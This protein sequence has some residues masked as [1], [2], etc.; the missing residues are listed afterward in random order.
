MIKEIDKVEAL[1]KK[2]SLYAWSN[3][4]P[5]VEDTPW[6]IYIAVTN[7][8]NYRCKVCARGKVMRSKQ[9]FMELSLF[10]KIVDELP[11]DMK[12]VYIM[13]QGETLLHPKLP[14]IL[15]YLKEKRPDSNVALHT[16]ASRLTRQL[17][18]EITKYT[19]FL[20][21]TISGITPEVY[22]E[23][24]GKN[25]FE[26]VLNNMREFLLIREKNGGRPK[27]V[28]IDYVRQEGNRKESD[29][30]VFRF[31]EKN[32]PALTGVG[33]HWTFN[34]QGTIDEGNL[35][36]YEQLDYKSF[37][38]CIFPWTSL[39][40]CWDGKVDY[41]FTEPQEN[42]FLGDARRETLMEIWNNSKY[43]EFRRLLSE[44]KFD[45]L[46]R[47]GIFCRKCSWLWSMESQSVENIVQNSKEKAG[48]DLGASE[49]TNAE[50]H[51]LAGLKHY[52]KGNL[53]FAYQNFY[54][55]QIVTDDKVLKL[56][57][58]KWM[59][60]VKKVWDMWQNKEKWEKCLNKEGRSL[61]DFYTRYHKIAK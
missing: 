2:S 24:H 22:K 23:V 29:E 13:K 51:L 21:I 46:E 17:S 18:E 56:K 33:I 4:L 31:F 8:C 11:K 14:Q 12:R 35:K 59:N 39:T 45:V 60:E 30:E 42:Y 9:G 19:D 48:D 6:V 5:T 26:I 25:N 27:K 16:N 3:F 36:I 34:F 15:R 52:L 55:A 47:K 20:S 32:F 57:A 49:I 54:L 44:K 40:I 61:S 53:S 58:E 7:I 38:L 50:K 1:C 37:P 41:C 43:Q 28:Y 10:K